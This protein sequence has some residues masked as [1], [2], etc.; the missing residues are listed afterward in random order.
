MEVAIGK[1]LIGQVVTFIHFLVQPH[2]AGS[3]VDF[4][5]TR[6]LKKKKKKKKKALKD[7]TEGDPVRNTN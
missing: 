5:K 1:R 3:H 2:M 6:S 7:Y 4:Y